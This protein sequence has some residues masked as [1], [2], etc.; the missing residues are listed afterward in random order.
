MD[1]VY[2]FGHGK[3]YENDGRTRR[4]PKKQYGKPTHKSKK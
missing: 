1:D 4:D 2:T 3:L